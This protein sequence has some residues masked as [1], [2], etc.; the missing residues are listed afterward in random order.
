MSITVDPTLLKV[1]I[2]HWTSYSLPAGASQDHLLTVPSH[3]TGATLF[4]LHAS[5]TGKFK[6]V[7]KIKDNYSETVVATLYTSLSNPSLQMELGNVVLPDK[8]IIVQVLN[9]DLVA[10][11]CHVMLRHSMEDAYDVFNRRFTKQLDKVLE[12][13]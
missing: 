7:L 8:T 3:G 10:C 11:D 13:E 1:E 12:E 4:S 6:F 5:T 2:K 9:L